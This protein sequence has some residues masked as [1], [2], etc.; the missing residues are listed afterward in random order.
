MKKGIALVLTLAVFVCM[1]SVGF[2]AGAIYYD[3]NYVFGD[4]DG[5]NVVNL[6]DAQNALKMSA[7]I[8][9]AEDPEAYVR[10]DINCDGFVTLNDARQILRSVAGIDLEPSGA[11]NGFESNYSAS[12]ESAI[13]VFNLALNMLKTESDGFAVGFTRN[14]KTEILKVDPGSIYTSGGTAIEGASAESIKNL[15]SGFIADDGEGEWSSETVGYGDTDYSKMEILFAPY[16][17]KLTVDDVLGLKVNFDT[18]NM[19]MT[20][21]VALPDTEVESVM[22]SS[23]AKAY[24]AQSMKED[25]DSI[26]SKLLAKGDSATIRKFT[27]GVLTVVIDMS[28][29]QIRVESY[30][31]EHKMYSYIAETSINLLV[32][33]VKTKGFTLERKTTVLYDNFQWDYV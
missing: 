16:V 31:M 29:P 11:F 32:G 19:K 22:S 12:P 5:N 33:T 6:L 25:S 28:G 7:G 3:K 20:I 27:N 8:Y 14:E 18:E 2:N 15:I 30:Q 13:A 26:I 10:G 1:L 24:N 21:S 17:S 9:V 4:I 23:Y